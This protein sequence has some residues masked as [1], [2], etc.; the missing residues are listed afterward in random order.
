ML[1]PDTKYSRTPLM[2][3]ELH[4]KKYGG[5]NKLLMVE[6]IVYSIKK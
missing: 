6:V 4:M 1:F 3:M 5:F 2:V